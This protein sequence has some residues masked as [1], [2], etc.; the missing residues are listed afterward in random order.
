MFKNIDADIIVYGHNHIPAVNNESNKWY[1][2]SG[3]LG[4][5]GNDCNIARAGIININNNNITYEE[6]NLH[7]D[8]KKVIKNIEDMKYPE[9]ENILKYFYGL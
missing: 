5:P 7:Y 9:F 1:I 3:S 6:L 4:C 2:N 8:V